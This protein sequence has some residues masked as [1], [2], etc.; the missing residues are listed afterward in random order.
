MTVAPAV[1]L[2]LWHAKSAKDTEGVLKKV[3]KA[4]S[5]W[6]NEANNQALYST[7]F[8]IQWNHFFKKTIMI[9]QMQQTCWLEPRGKRTA[10]GCWRCVSSTCHYR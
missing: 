1:R 9:M 6:V 2:R 10:T 7:G 5:D 8:I 4:G 3:K